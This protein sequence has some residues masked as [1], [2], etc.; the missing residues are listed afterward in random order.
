MGDALSSSTSKHS[1]NP[2][3]TDTRPTPRVNPNYCPV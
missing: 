2:R 1:A 3:F